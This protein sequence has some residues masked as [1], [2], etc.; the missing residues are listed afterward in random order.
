MKQPHI[1]CSKEDVARMVILPGD[2]A[3]VDRVAKY[4]D[5]YEEI[6]NNREFKTLKG[7]Y[8]GMEVSIVST[9]IGGA[10]S[11]IALEELIACGGEYFIR[12]GSLGAYQSN[13]A[14]GDLIIAE[15]AVREEGASKMYIGDIYPAVSNIEII[16]ALKKK[17]EELNYPHHLGLVRSHDSFYID[18]E[19][20]VVQYWSSK[21]V[22]GGDMETATLMTLGRLRGVKV[23]SILNNVV[24]FK[25]DV[26]DGINNYVDNDN[27]AEE[28]ERREIILALETLYEIS[29]NL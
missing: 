3:R 18:N 19:D 2:P 20:E 16:E 17:A 12:I 24:L 23:G 8:K 21:G 13:I 7:K 9:G 26:K 15:G 6:A 11:C 28:G 4:L 27:M 22:L 5:E 10:S 25:G 1:Q 29:R 14:I